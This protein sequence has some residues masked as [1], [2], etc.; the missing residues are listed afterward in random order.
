MLRNLLVLATAS[1]MAMNSLNAETLLI[2]G[3]SG[4]P[5]QQGNKN[6]STGC[7]TNVPTGTMVVGI[8][9]N[10]NCLASYPIS[11]PVGS[12]IDTVEVAYHNVYNG[13]QQPS[14]AAYLAKHSFVPETNAI[15]VAATN[16]VFG[17]QSPSLQH[18]YMPALGMPSLSI[19]VLPDEIF[20]VQVT[21]SY[22]TE[23]CSITLRYH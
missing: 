15:A 4:I 17:G 20:W 7:I 3:V 10:P 2:P 19:P 21:T 16:T 22:I 12:T 13:P 11:L 6:V 1:L 14:I 23:I 5:D 18:L 9:V 8:L